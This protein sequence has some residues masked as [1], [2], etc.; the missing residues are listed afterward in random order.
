MATPAALKAAAPSSVPAVPSTSELVGGLLSRYEDQIARALPK[1]LSVERFS[2]VCLTAVRSTPRLLQCDGRSLIAA[3]ML[4]AQTG[5][6]PGPL[7]HAYFVPKKI[8]GE[9]SVVWVM[10]YKGILD[11]ANRSGVLAR[12]EAHVV[13]ANDDYEA[14]YGSNAFLRHRPHDGDRG[15]V[16]GAYCLWRGRGDGDVQWRYMSRSQIEAVRAESASA[17]SDFSPWNTPLGYLA[18]CRKSPIRASLPY[19]P[20][21]IEL[22]GAATAD[23]RVHTDLSD[24]MLAD[25]IDVVDVKEASDAPPPPGELT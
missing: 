20:T 6:E 8:K 11:L 21:S 2:R 23:D 10:G 4:S 18:M 12:I 13:Y 17:G 9:W 22:V 1:N 24:D 5:L 7:G 14:E 25:V 3:V 16:R 19:L 15:D